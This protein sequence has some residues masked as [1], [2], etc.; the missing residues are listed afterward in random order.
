MYY[1]DGTGNM[2]LDISGDSHG[3]EFETYNG[4]GNYAN[5]WVDFDNDGDTDFHLTKCRQGSGPGDD[6]RIN[7]FYRNNGDN[8]FTEIGVESNLNDGEQSWTSVWEDF[9]HDGYFDLFT[10]NH[11]QITLFLILE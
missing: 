4:P 7:R 2:S 9:D 3:V 11:T 8:T 1:N 6:T 10:V 5:M